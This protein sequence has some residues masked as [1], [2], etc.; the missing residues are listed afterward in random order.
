MITPILSRL[1]TPEEYGFFSLMSGVT[2]VLV[3]ISNITLPQS[4]LT[5]TEDKIEETSLAIVELSLIV[6]LIFVLFSGLAMRFLEKPET[7]LPFNLL[8]IVLIA[9]SSFLVTLTQILANLNIRDKAFGKNV[10]V[11]IAESVS[12][13]FIG[14][15]LGFLGLAKYGLFLADLSGKSTNL[16]TQVAFKKGAVDLY[17]NQAVLDM[18][19][20]KRVLRENRNYLYFNLPS[21]LIASFFNQIV[22][23]ILALSFSSSYVGYFTMALSLLSMPLVLLA[24]SLQPLIT[25][26]LI[27]QNGMLSKRYFIRVI[28]II[29]LISLGTYTIIYFLSPYFI[30]IYL[31]E[32]W[33][34]TI[35]IAKVLCLPFSLQ[36]LGNSIQGAFIVFNK[37]RSNLVIKVIFLGLLFLSL[38]SSWVV[39]QGPETLVLAYAIIVSI[40]EL[41]KI[42]YLTLRLK[43][44]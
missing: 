1:Y 20:L 13:R 23:W 5:V 32:N 21:S 17:R 36:L 18:Q 25:S 40:E 30:Q 8:S 2:T 10:I 41:V 22:L 7:T 28:S 4:L 27:T 19:R 15:A 31:G 44:V 3:L 33:V 37:Q 38:N 26:K 34:Q 42:L 35:G 12:A 29:L 14:L 16:F 43:Y 11:S 6:N 24:N 39:N 9:G